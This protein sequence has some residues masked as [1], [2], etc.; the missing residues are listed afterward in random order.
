MSFV[1]S[2]CSSP[3]QS[4]PDG[5]E[6]A[7]AVAGQAGKALNL[8]EKISRAEVLEGIASVVGRPLHPRHRS[9]EN[10]KN[11]SAL[12]PRFD[13]GLVGRNL[14]QRHVIPDLFGAVAEE[15]L[16]VR[17]LFL[18]QFFKDFQIHPSPWNVQLP[19][20][21]NGTDISPC[22]P[23]ISAI[24]HNEKGHVS[25]SGLFSTFFHNTGYI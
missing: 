14:H 8:S 15:K 7:D 18:G 21:A 6:D 2:P 1:F 23:I 17:S 13:K 22:E 12:R 11:L 19:E 16:H 5:R 4:R 20:S 10:H 3:R 25:F 24:S 9:G